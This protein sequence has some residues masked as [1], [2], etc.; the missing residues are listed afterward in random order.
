MITP[1]QK[2]VFRLI[3]NGLLE[4]DLWNDIEDEDI[5]IDAI[6][7]IE[8]L[9]DGTTRTQLIAIQ[10]FCENIDEPW[11]DLDDFIEVASKISDGLEAVTI[12]AGHPSGIVSGRTLTIVKSIYI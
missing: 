7:D 8:P 2:L 12:A 4:R 11:D 1:I 10:G 9:E 6:D 3:K 5:L